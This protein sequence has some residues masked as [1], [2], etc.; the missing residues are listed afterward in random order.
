[1][2]VPSCRMGC[3]LLAALLWTGLV[4][5]QAPP[6]GLT[7]DASLER[8]RVPACPRERAEAFR[9]HWREGELS[10]SLAELSLDLTCSRSGNRGAEGEGN[11]LSLLLTLPP[12]D[13]SI[14]QLTLYLPGDAVLAGPA[15]LRR[16]DTGVQVDWH[17][18]AGALAVL[19]RPDQG[20][21]R[22][23]GELPG[24]LLL[25]SLSGPVQ[26]QGDWRPGQ[27]LQLTATTA[28]PAPLAGTLRLNGVLDTTERGWQWRPETRL[29]MET[30]AW[31]QLRLRGL[32]LRPASTLPLNGLGRWTLGW[33]DG[34]WQ[35]QPL[36]GAELDLALT[37]HRHGGLRL[38][39]NPE[40]QVSGHWQWQQG[41]MLTLPE[42]TLSLAAVAGWL[43]GWLQLPAFEVDSGELRLAGRIGSQPNAVPA[44]DLVLKDGRLRR[45]ELRAEQ[46]AGRLG[47][48]WRNGRPALSPHSGLAI[49]ELSTGVPV[50]DIHAALDWRQ[51]GPWLSG[52]TGKVLEGRLALSPMPLSTPTQGEL[53]LQDISLARLLNLAAVPGLTGDGKLQGRLPFVM[54]GGVSVANGR[55]WGR[56]GWVSYQA[57][58]SL[59][60]T[61]EDNLSLSLTLGMLQD[62]RYHHLD[63][64]VSMAGDGEAVVLTRLQGQA[65]VAGKLHP[66]NF[67]YRHQENLLQLL[68]S[69]RFAGQLSERLPARLQG[70]TNQ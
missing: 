37:D 57:G 64:E 34:R 1:M 7:L 69:L 10:G 68:A 45:G 59:A 21:W 6:P 35:Q 13:F 28:L 38:R 23:Q 26:M 54:A 47:L 53:H 20:G 46:V 14:E 63:A 15:L 12:I 39:L 55:V 51:G 50:T 11:A 61:A 16:S 62:L 17:T 65:P 30:L 5:A 19:L 22:W 44:L 52:L 43:N 8:A 31:R 56:D 3:C 41:L 18:E 36:P 4:S 42:Q 25:P 40:L 24:R 33:Q 29:T 49:G 48:V 60:T 66:V 27:A 67:N 70:E 58:E 32:S 9:L 2:T